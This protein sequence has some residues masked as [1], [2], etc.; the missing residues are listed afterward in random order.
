MYRLNSKEKLNC[1]IIDDNNVS[2]EHLKSKLTA[3]GFLNFICSYINPLTALREIEHLQNIDVIFIEANMAEMSG[4]EFAR[5]ITHHAAHI[6]FTANDSN[7]C[8]NAFQVFAHVYLL[9]PVKEFDLTKV[10]QTIIKNRVEHSNTELTLQPFVLLKG[11]VK[12]KYLRMELED[13]ILIYK[14]MHL[15]FVATMKGEFQLNTTMANIERK[16]SHYRYFIRVHQSN[17]INSN[18]LLKIEGNTIY[19]KNKWT[20]PV[21]EFYRANIRKFISSN[22]LNP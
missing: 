14:K 10:T 17:L 13:I 2:T 7:Y 8:W 3:L 11:E 15:V 21:G 22:L 19:L 12:G 5:N 18:H 1:V 16:L 20:V 9:K 6:I 4:F